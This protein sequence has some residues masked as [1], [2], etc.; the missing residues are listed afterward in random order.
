M[1]AGL[2]VDTAGFTPGGGGMA[3]V[4]SDWFVEVF[5]DSQVG[6]RCVGRGTLWENEESDTVDMKCLHKR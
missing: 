3:V 1:V 6:G 5:H 2:A 4:S